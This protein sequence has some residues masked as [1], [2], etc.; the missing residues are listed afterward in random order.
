MSDSSA[1]AELAANPMLLT[2]LAIIGRGQ[3]LPRERRTAYEHAVSVLVERWDANRQLKRPGVGGGIGPLG[4]RE[5]LELLRRAARYMQEG[6]AGWPA[7]AS[8]GRK[9]AD[10]FATY[11]QEEFEQPTGEARRI[12]DTLIDQF[13]ERD[14]ILARFGTEV[15]GFVHRAFLDYLAADDIYGQF[16]EHALNRDDIVSTFR[17]RWSDQAWQEVL[18]LLAG[19]IPETVAGQAIGEMLRV[20]PLWYQG[21]DPVPRNVLLA[22]RCLGEVRRRGRLAEQSR[23]ISTALI[24]LLETVSD[25][26]FDLGSPLAQALE[27]EVLPTLAEL[28]PHW[29]GRKRYETWYLTRGQFLGARCRVSPR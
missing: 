26:D 2:I 12:A 1:V 21:A 8:P 28:G 20:N 24:C 3:E 4:S 18:L 9:L 10:M 7:T 29:A 19:M 27:R 22:I 25:P 5:K 13:R 11:F 16:S 14:Y 15:Y 23:D 17:D 6:A